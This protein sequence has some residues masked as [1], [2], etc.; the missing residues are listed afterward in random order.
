METPY[1]SNRYRHLNWQI[2]VLCDQVAMFK[3][4]IAELEKLRSVP[5][6]DEE[7]IDYH[8]EL[9]EQA[10]E[11]AEMEWESLMMNFPLDDDP[12]GDPYP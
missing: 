12:A 1:N 8:V 4:R 9:W 6:A 5:D 7:R 10:K 3:S 11:T 2:E